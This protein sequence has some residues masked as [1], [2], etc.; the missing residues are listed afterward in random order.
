MGQDKITVHDSLQSGNSTSREFVKGLNI[1]TAVAPDVDGVWVLNPPYLLFYRDENQ[2]LQPDGPPEVHLEGFGLEDTHSV[3]NSLCFGP[4]GWLYAAQGSTVSGAVRRYGTNEPPIKSMGQLIWR[5]HPQSRQYEVF[6]EGGGN[7][8]G[9]AFDDQGQLF[10]GHNGGDTRGFH[11]E[12]GGYYRKGF[13]K[14]GELSNPYA[15]G[16]L[17]PM[18]HDPIQRFT[19]TMLLTEGTAL[20]SDAPKAMIAVDPLHGTLFHTE[21]LA[22][23][24]TYQTRDIGV[25]VKSTD[26]WF[27]P[28]AITD[29]PDGAAYVCDWYDS[30]VAH[31]YA[32][33]GMLD[34]DHGRVYRLHNPQKTFENWD[35]GLVSSKDLA[36]LDRLVEKLSSPLRWQRWAARRLIAVHPLREQARF[37]LVQM[38]VNED[39]YSLDAFWTVNAC[40]WVEGT[41]LQHGKSGPPSALEAFLK[42][43]QPRIREWAV[44]LSCDDQQLT[45]THQQLLEDLI[46]KEND[47]QVLLQVAASA[48]RLPASNA[49]H[50]ARCLFARIDDSQDDAM[51][52][53]LW[54]LVERHA[55]EHALIQ[56]ALVNNQ[57]IWQSGIFRNEIVPRLLKRWLLKGDES[58]LR[59]AGTLVD[60][61]AIFSGSQKA[62]IVKA[63]NDAFETTS[64]GRSLA[65]IPDSLIAALTK[66]GQPSLTLRLRRGDPAAFEEAKLAIKDNDLPV[67][68]KVRLVAV[69]NEVR[70]DEAGSFLTAVGLDANTNEEVRVA[71][72]LALQTYVD[73]A[74]AVNYLNQFDKLSPRIKVALV[75]TLATRKEWSM[76]LMD[77]INAN[78]IEPSDLPVEVIR[79]IRLHDDPNLQ[80]QVSRLYPE[81][82]G[83]NLVEAQKAAQAIVEKVNKISGDPYRGKKLY[84]ENC[85]RCH[86]L[87]EEGGSLGPDLT[88]YQRDQATALAMNVLAP[89]LELREGFQTYAVLTTDGKVLNGFVE[90][91]TEDSI[92][93]RSIDDQVH[94]IDRDDIESF[95][96]MPNSLMPNGLL[97]KMEEQQ[98]ADLFAYLRSSQP[99]ND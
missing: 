99:L 23:A 82:Q 44:R 9:V 30:Q 79:S 1:A 29:G 86:R 36:T 43:C 40:G 85:G 88:S 31:I 62:T 76:L 17:M 52:L 77:A 71:A 96:P 27:R 56:E 21:L 42:Y 5:Y 50:L 70:F 15:F 35:P 33:E 13:S 19:H 72:V 87:F 65:N 58:D 39:S 46:A 26:K 61:V 48:R 92:L 14:H 57:R 11:Y 59:A 7:A 3:V 34:R 73:T 37:K 97:D 91:E 75:T 80:E 20:Q 49:L 83:M 2:D 25:A 84:A 98:I 41:I 18:Q 94:V 4:D 38:C 66:L 74:F 68:S 16:F 12:Q 28:V 55:D 53:M 67:D 32:H 24:T 93:I 6:A 95:K 89:N 54:W 60:Q 69:M 78:K 47:E 45:P 8:F 22:S 64:A 10:S 63:V 90:R 81:L 51:K